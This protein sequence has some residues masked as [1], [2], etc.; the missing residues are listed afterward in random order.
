VAL[1]VPGGMN[2]GFKSSMTHLDVYNMQL[3]NE[4]AEELARILI[5]SGK[6]AFELCGLFA[7]GACVLP[8]IS[9]RRLD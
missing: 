5:D 7:G 9:G 6:G 8:E 1:S 2:T 3:S 4:P